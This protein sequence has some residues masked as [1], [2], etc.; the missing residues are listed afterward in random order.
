MRF[1]WLVGAAL[2]AFL[3]FA[4]PAFAQYKLGD[5]VAADFGSGYLDS[6]IVK[7]D[8]QSP[9]P[10]RVHPLGYTPYMDSSF[11]AQMLK[12][13]GSVPTKP[14]GGIASD[15]E[16]L[17]LKGQKAFHPTKI[18]AGTYEC[19]AYSGGRLEPRPGLNFTILDGSHYRDGGGKTGGY[20]FDAASGMLA[21]SGGAF[22]GQQA[23]YEQ[24]TSPPTKNQPPS[25]TLA[26]SGDSCELPVR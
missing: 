26:T 5:R 2:A 16:L 25:I 7:V 14:I 20:R 1:G 22:D 10:F 6:V 3:S 12:P 23:K 21:F 24:A 15:P 17:K 19:Y 9:Y 8:P 13:Y 11:S 4:P 18:L